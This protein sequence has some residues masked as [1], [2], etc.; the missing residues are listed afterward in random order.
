MSAIATTPATTLKP[1]PA[2]LSDESKLLLLP[3]GVAALCFLVSVVQS[4]RR[5]EIQ[6]PGILVTVVIA[7]IAA[8]LIW[9][10]EDLQDKRERLSGWLASLVVCFVLLGTGCALIAGAVGLVNNE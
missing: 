1:I 4:A 7:G 8:A 9:K 5:K 2:G 10:H 6:W 3:S